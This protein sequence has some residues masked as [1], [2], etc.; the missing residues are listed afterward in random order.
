M[1]GMFFGNCLRY[2]CLKEGNKFLETEIRF[3]H[4][5]TFAMMIRI[6]ILNGSDLPLSY[7]FLILLT[8]LQL[9]QHS[10]SEFT[11]KEPLDTKAET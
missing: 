2:F 9:S 10:S 11:E 7:Y 5:G 6:E 8:A 3:L 1:F 4:T